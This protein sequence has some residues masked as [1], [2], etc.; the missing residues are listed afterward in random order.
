MFFGVKKKTKVLFN[1]ILIKIFIQI[2]YTRRAC[3]QIT[4]SLLFDIQYL[5]FSI[6][7]SVSGHDVLDSTTV[8]TTKKTIKLKEEEKVDKLVVG[9][10]KVRGFKNK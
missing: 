6:L 5:D 7:D 10:P 2:F 4:I 8:A 3:F 1:L 9:I